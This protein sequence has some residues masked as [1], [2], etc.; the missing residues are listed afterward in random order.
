MIYVAGLAYLLGSISFSWLAVRLAG[1]GDLR[2][3]GSGN[4]GAKNTLRSLGLP[5]AL[6]VFIG[7]FAKGWLALF[8]ADKLG[9]SELLLVAAFAVILGHNFPF[10]LRFQGGKGLAAAA[11]AT[12][13]LNPVLTLTLLFSGALGLAITRR[14]NPAAFFIIAS[15]PLLTPL[16]TDLPQSW[17]WSP[18]IAV[19]V[20]YRHLRDLP[21][22]LASLGFKKSRY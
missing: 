22:L 3:Q 16:L 12:L 9:G 15:F 17:L 7:D 4:L 13:Y 1:R 18:L 2:R 20:L 5:A 8:M 11:G 10:W 6:A 14:T 19:V 21:D